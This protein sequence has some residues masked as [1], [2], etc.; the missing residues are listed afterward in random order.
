MTWD[1]NRSSAG[2]GYYSCT[3]RRNKSDDVSKIFDLRDQKLIKS[4]NNLL[5]PSRAFVINLDKRPDRWETFQ[6]HN[7]LLLENF[8]VQRFSGIEKNPPKD[9]IFESF[10]KCMELGFQTEESIIIM[11]DDCYLVPGAIDKIKKAWD[12]L[13]SD[14]DC[15]I[16]NHYLIYGIDVLTDNIAKPRSR[17]STANFCIFRNTA[18]TKITGNQHLRVNHNSH[19]D[20]FLTSEETPINNYTIWPM[21]SREYLSFS[22]HKG[23]VRN[24][25][26]YIAEHSYLYQFIDGDDYYTS[27]ESW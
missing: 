2:P 25:E 23:K 21:V 1:P 5:F 15:L 22:D 27:L 11:E 20:H 18:L 12:D 7:K 6:H 4:P 26:P 17:A 19:I 10:T 13:P 24:M 8:E 14:W 3:S 9:G 16:G